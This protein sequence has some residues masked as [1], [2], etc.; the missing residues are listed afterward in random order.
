MARLSFISHPFETLLPQLQQVTPGLEKC[1]AIYYDNFSKQTVAVEA[2]ENG[3]LAPLNADFSLLQK[4]RRKV[5]PTD[6]IRK[7]DMPFDVKESGL[8]QLTIND[9]LKNN[10][11]VMR[12]KNP[13]DEKSDVVYLFFN[14]HFGNFRLSKTDDVL[15]AG[16]KNII[17]NLLYKTWN[18]QIKQMRNDFVIWQ[19]LSRAEQIKHARE[20]ELQQKW[21]DAQQQLRDT[22]N[23]SIRY[24]LSKQQN[25]TAKIIVTDKAVDKIAALRLPLEQVELLLE[26]ALVLAENKVSDRNEIVISESEIIPE[27]LPA[28][29]TTPTYT[30]DETVELRYKKTKN[31]LDRYE[32]AA[33]RLKRENKPITGANIGAAC[34]PSVSHAA[35]SDVLKKHRNKI[36]SLLQKYPD[37]WPILRSEFRAVKNLTDNGHF[38]QPVEKSA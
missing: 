5:K 10:V 8:E 31:F 33:Q 17:Q 36:I 32:Q 14:E 21:K 4:E 23:N 34:R 3:E 29:N 35:I 19:T 7:T 9:E 12:F 24:I 37:K 1:V 2:F 22:V 18:E 16:A 26:Q 30:D 6:W 13:D 25:T 27:L 38:N 11:L 20:Q 28:T 15:T